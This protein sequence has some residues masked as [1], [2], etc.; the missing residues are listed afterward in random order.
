MKE[1][2]LCLCVCEGGGGELVDDRTN[3]NRS[4]EIGTDHSS[5]YDNE[6][7]GGKFWVWGNLGAT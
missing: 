4:L 1:A 2:G 3:R 5:V 6:N 7:E